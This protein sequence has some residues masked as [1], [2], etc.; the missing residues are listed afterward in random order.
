MYPRYSCAKGE[1][2][3]VAFR[4]CDCVPARSLTDRASAEEPSA[5]R[6]RLAELRA[7]G[8]WLAGMAASSERSSRRRRTVHCS[9]AG[10]QVRPFRCRDRTRERAAALFSTHTLAARTV[11]VRALGP[12]L[13]RSD[14]YGA[15]LLQHALTGFRRCR[16]PAAL[17]AGWVRRYVGRTAC[18]PSAR[19]GHLRRVIDHHNCRSRCKLPRRYRL[20]S[21]GRR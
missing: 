17:A 7:I 2:Q 20:S 1:C 11:R 15:E 3:R 9:H 12:P 19:G 5:D 21:A 4:L 6:R 16:A 18:R 10:V 13:S 14:H 8:P